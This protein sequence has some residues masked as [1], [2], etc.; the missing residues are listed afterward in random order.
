MKLQF[1]EINFM[2]A[3]LRTES[4]TIVNRPKARRDPPDKTVLVSQI[5][6]LKQ[7]LPG[8]FDPALIKR[9]IMLLTGK[10]EGK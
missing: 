9:A 2:M 10:V 7:D 3:E 8:L 5:A 6:K 4:A 1:E